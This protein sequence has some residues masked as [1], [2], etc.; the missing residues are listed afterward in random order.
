MTAADTGTYTSE[1]CAALIEKCELE[2][3]E[4]MAKAARSKALYEEFNAKIQAFWLQY[5]LE[6]TTLIYRGVFDPTF[7]RPNDTKVK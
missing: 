5:N 7:C 2:M 6:M 1:E 3:R 4:S